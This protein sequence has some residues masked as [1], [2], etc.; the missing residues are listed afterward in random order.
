VKS[1]CNEKF[2]HS[3]KDLNL[4][5]REYWNKFWSSHP[6]TAL[7]TLGEVIDH[8]KLQHLLS[9]MPKKG[10]SVEIGCGSARISSW[11]ANKGYET[12]AI[13]YS[14]SALKGAKSSY[15]RLG[16]LGNFVCGDAF[17]LP[18]KNET[19]DIVLST[20]LLEHFSNPFPVVIEMMRI[21]KAGGLFYADI[22][23]EKFSIFG[24]LKRLGKKVLDVRVDS[25]EIYAKKMN[26]KE[27]RKL[28]TISG[29]NSV[30]IY[31]MAVIIPS[32]KS[33]ELLRSSHL[34][35]EV[36]RKRCYWTYVKSLDKTKLCS[37]LGWYFFCYGWK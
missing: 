18:F 15:A 27:I 10:I 12:F 33:I 9:I 36:V 31:G 28:L 14:K 24:L 1:L 22:V 19:V 13:D 26:Q 5:Q 32:L 21:L 8:A 37:L 30:H 3:L 23:P 7:D 11:L 17:Q 20:G 16:S 35:K 29:L 34:E 25:D 4:K 6:G 2:D